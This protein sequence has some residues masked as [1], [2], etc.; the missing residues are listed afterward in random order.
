MAI[1]L[2]V[3]G[4]REEFESELTILEFLKKKKIWIEMVTVEVN[5]KII[6]KQDYEKIALKENDRVETVFYM[7]GGMHRMVRAGGMYRMVHSGGMSN[8][9]LTGFN[10][11]E[12][13]KVQNG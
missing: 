1:K 10:M 8:M 2:I 13:S 5:D 6:Q 11:R 9:P 4:K 7:G 12:Y 3:S